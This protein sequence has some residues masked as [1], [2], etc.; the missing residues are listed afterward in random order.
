[1]NK[2]DLKLVYVLKI[3]YDSKQQGLYEFLFSKDP[4]VIPTDELGWNEI[5]ANGVAEPPT[6]KD[7]DFILSLKTNKIDFICLHESNDR[8]YMDGYYTIHCLAYENVESNNSDSIF[9]EETTLLV[10]HYGMKMREVKE[11][12]F[13]RD[14]QLKEVEVNKPTVAAT[15]DEEADEEDEE[16]QF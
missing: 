4:S 8:S 7:I 13:S 10:F 1:M 11:Y 14:I 12:F 3:G 6:E 15:S 2:D 5:P 16:L 9:G